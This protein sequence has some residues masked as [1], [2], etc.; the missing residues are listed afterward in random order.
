M[1][2]YS[3]R[4]YD[5]RFPSYFR[6]EKVKLSRIL[7]FAK[8]IEHIGSTAV[9]GLGGKG[10][11]DVYMTVPKVKIRLLEK[12][13]VEAGYSFMHSQMDEDGLRLMFKKVYTHRKES[14]VVHVHVAENGS[15]NF[16]ECLIFRDNLRKNK[17]LVQEYEAIKIK[18]TKDEQLK[19]E[20]QDSKESLDKAKKIYMKFKEPF[21]VKYSWRRV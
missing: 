16:E 5:K 6:Y 1:K 3:F 18:A 8:N 20:K 10:I 7:P 13:M 19:K 4:P 2:K 14:R 11:L 17:K 15:R 12:I 9:P 21:I